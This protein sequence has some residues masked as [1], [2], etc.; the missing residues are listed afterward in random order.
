MF[1]KTQTDLNAKGV[2]GSR[3]GSPEMW[4]LGLAWFSD[5]AVLGNSQVPSVLSLCSRQG[6]P[7]PEAGALKVVKVARSR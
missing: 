4:A 7:C 2:I 6:L 5:S 3:A 1:K